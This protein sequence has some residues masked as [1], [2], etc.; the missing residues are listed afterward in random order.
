LYS[1]S[2]LRCR[3]LPFTSHLPPLYIPVHVLSIIINIQT[4]ASNSL[5]DSN[6]PRHFHTSIGIPSG[7]IALPPSVLFKA[8]L[9]FDSCIL[10]TKHL[11]KSSKE[12]SNWLAWCHTVSYSMRGSTSTML[13][14]PWHRWNPCDSLRW[15]PRKV[16]TFII[17]TSSRPFLTTT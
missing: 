1:R 10:R 14:P 3:R 15:Q 6:I 17:W 16:G 5:T 9:T 4:H 8:S 12:S 7:P 11:F 2:F 13:S